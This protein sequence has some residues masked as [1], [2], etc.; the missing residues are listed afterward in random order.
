[1]TMKIARSGRRVAYGFLLFPKNGI[2]GKLPASDATGR[3]ST[4]SGTTS[5]SSSSVAAGTCARGA[6]AP[7]AAPAG[8]STNGCCE[9]DRYRE[10]RNFA[11]HGAH[12]CDTPNSL[13]TRPGLARQS[14]NG[15]DLPPR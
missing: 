14:A 1:M 15:G 6:S 5:T 4:V 9:G 7:G 8:C 12:S 11:E 3:A 10:N 2:M 13:C